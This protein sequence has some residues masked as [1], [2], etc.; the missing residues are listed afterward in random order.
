[1]N[2]LTLYKILNFILLPF[3]ALFGFLSVIMFFIA[4]AN[5]ALLLLVFIIIGFTVYTI[6]CSIFLFKGINNNQPC[7]PKLKDWIKVNGYVSV[8][9]GVMM[10]MNT[11]TLLFT[12]KSELRPYAEQAVAAYPVKS[13]G[14]NADALLN[15]MMAV[16]YGMLVFS[17]ALLIHLFITFR[18][19]KKY[20]HLFGDTAQ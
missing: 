13:P 8:A 11:I 10:L 20:Q 5:P 12:K 15:A 7:K 18:L 1:M 4:L 19:I 16:S 3:A 14:I 17:I 2:Q 9:M 6:A